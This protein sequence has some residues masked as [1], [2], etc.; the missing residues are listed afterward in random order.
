MYYVLSFVYKHKI[1]HN[2]HNTTALCIYDNTTAR[3]DDT[4]TQ[5]DDTHSDSMLEYA[6]TKAMREGGGKMKPRNI[7]MHG[8][9]GVGKTSLKRLILGQLPLNKEEESSTD[10]MEKAV[11]AVS[12]H[13]LKKDGMKLLVAV[14]NEEFITMLA[15]NVG[16]VNE[17]LQKKSTHDNILVSV[18]ITVMLHVN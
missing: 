11:R 1:V 18:Y 16:V 9:P 10:I 17:E 8:P 12:T 4:T 6:L 3:P 13:R 15:Q 2:Y 14:D 5:D 7:T